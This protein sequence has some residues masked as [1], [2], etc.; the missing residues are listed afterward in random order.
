MFEQKEIGRGEGSC[1]D[2]LIDRIAFLV[3]EDGYTHLYI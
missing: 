1:R 3:T 2:D